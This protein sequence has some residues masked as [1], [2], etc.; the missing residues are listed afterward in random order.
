M[1][2]SAA[3]KDVILRKTRGQFYY[4]LDYDVIIS[5]RLTEIQAYLEWMTRVSCGSTSLSF[6]N[7]IHFPGRRP[8]TVSLSTFGASYCLTS[9][10]QN[11]S[12]GLVRS[13]SLNDVHVVVHPRY[14]ACT[15]CYWF[16]TTTPA[17]HRIYHTSFCPAM[18]CCIFALE[19]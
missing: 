15:S 12:N 10:L 1:D 11:S 7:S 6:A 4:E 9:A 17:Y 18:H 3:V 5:F 19:P 16:L 13:R 2:L 14:F 8:A